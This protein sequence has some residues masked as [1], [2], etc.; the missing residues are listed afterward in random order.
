MVKSNIFITTL[1]GLNK[2]Q[3]ISFVEHSTPSG[4]QHLLPFYT[5]N[6]IGGYS[7]LIPSG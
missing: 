4:L 5:P 7:Y 3:K 6:F 2:K 1:K